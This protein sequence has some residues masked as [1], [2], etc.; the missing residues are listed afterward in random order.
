MKGWLLLTLFCIACA[1]IILPGDERVPFTLN[2][3]STAY[4]ETILPSQVLRYALYVQPIVGAGYNRSSMTVTVSVEIGPC[5]SNFLVSGSAEVAGITYPPFKNLTQYNDLTVYTSRV[6]VNIEDGKVAPFIFHVNVSSVPSQLPSAKYTIRAWANNS[7]EIIKEGVD[8]PGTCGTLVPTYDPDT[9]ISEVN[10]AFAYTRRVYGI[11]YHLC[12]APSPADLFKMDVFQPAN[13]SNVCCYVVRAGLS[14]QIMST[15]LLRERHT[16]ITVIAVRGASHTRYQV[17]NFDRGAIPIAARTVKIIFISAIIAITVLV[18]LFI[19]IHSI[20]NYAILKPSQ[21][22]RIRLKSFVIPI[23]LKGSR[24]VLMGGSVLHFIAAFATAML[25]PLCVVFIVTPLLGLVASILYSSLLIFIYQFASLVCIGFALQH[26]VL[27]TFKLCSQYTHVYENSYVTCESLSVSGCS[28][29]VIGS[30]TVLF[31]QLLAHLFNLKLLRYKS[32]LQ[33]QD[34][35]MRS[36]DADS[37][38]HFY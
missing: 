9:Y 4:G 8:R 33:Q 34:S 21:I 35:I 38:L 6:K 29:Y 13:I 10:M 37:Q 2:L 5:S 23:D 31:L 27:N 32:W 14:D 26:M 17:L 16:A 25:G 36:S 20:K 22:V 30:L 15:V 28:L 7:T 3:T 1:D 18:Y 24:Y 11:T 19:L 12:T